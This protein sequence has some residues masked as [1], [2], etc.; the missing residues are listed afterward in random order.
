[1]KKKSKKSLE[2]EN[3]KLQKM[4]FLTQERCNSL[5]ELADSLWEEKNDLRLDLDSSTLSFEKLEKEFRSL[6]SLV[7]LL[8]SRNFKV[9]GSG[10]ANET[11]RKAVV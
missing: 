7:S 9:F 4:L 3:K 2:L 11:Q 6:E 10:R 5:K 1:M 8:E